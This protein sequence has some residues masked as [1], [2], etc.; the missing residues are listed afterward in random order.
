M[1]A[2]N[3]W[4]FIHRENFGREDL[5]CDF[6]VED[7]PWSKARDILLAEMP[8]A[9]E[10][11]FRTDC[12]DLDRVRVLLPEVLFALR[13]GAF[14]DKSPSP[15]EFE[16]ENIT[17]HLSEEKFEEVLF[18]HPPRGAITFYWNIYSEDGFAQPR[19]RERIEQLLRDVTYDG[20][21]PDGL[22]GGAFGFIRGKKLELYTFP[23][24]WISIAERV[25]HELDRMTAKEKA[26][27]ELRF[28]LDSFM[29]LLGWE[30]V[31]T[32]LQK[33]RS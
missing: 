21:Y 18:A 26:S 16:P 14:E 24:N 25:H 23:V 9:K 2:S 3:F 11:I 6:G 19:G 31:N 5:C 22:S 27:K 10:W 4:K 20:E 32:T 15:Q 29:R 28:E 17:L 7:T 13:Y 33:L 12:P 8:Q 1:S 30:A